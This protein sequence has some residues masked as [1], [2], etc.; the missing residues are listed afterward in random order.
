MMDDPSQKKSS[1]KLQLLPLVSGSH[2]ASGSSNGQSGYTYYSC[3]C[4]FQAKNR[5]TTGHS[6]LVRLIS[7]LA[8]WFSLL[9][10]IFLTKGFGV[11]ILKYMTLVF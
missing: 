11:A 2:D 5:I 8:R 1:I 3:Q 4:H 6:F 10:E 7:G 9:K